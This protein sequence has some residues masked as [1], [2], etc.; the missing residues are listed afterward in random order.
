[1]RKW[2]GTFARGNWKAVA[3]VGKKSVFSAIYEAK[4]G[5]AGPTKICWEASHV[6]KGSN[7][8]WR[9]GLWGAP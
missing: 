6:G 1:M 7:D 5:E 3:R 4:G 8:T 2:K 9:A